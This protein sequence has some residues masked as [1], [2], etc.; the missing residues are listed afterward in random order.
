MGMGNEIH[1]TPQ[2]AQAANGN[3][4][5]L[6]KTSLENKVIQNFCSKNLEM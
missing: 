2:M 4:I 3:I 1:K 6:E 5:L